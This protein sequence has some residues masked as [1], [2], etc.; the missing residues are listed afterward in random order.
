MKCNACR[1]RKLKQEL[2]S[3]YLLLRVNGWP[4][5]YKLDAPPASGQGPPTTNRGRSIRFVAAFMALEHTYDE[6]CKL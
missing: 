2:G 3:K 1:N 6:D 5:V 4:T